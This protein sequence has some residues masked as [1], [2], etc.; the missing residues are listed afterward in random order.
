MRE[1][2]GARQRKEGERGRESGR[3]GGRDGER[4]RGSE[5]EGGSEKRG[6]DERGYVERGLERGRE[7]YRRLEIR[8]SGK[9]MALRDTEKTRGMI[10]H[11]WL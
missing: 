3:E 11:P 7:R 6:A 4:R 1:G 8:K 10:C 2:E 9:K 5:R